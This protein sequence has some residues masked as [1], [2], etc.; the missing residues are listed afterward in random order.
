MRLTTSQGTNFRIIH[1]HTLA[2]AVNF[3]RLHLRASL[4]K[5]SMRSSIAR[6]VSRQV[7]YWNAGAMEFDIRVHS[8]EV[9]NLWW[10]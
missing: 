1:R 2:C 7:S 8:R 9:Y 10:S 4:P 5:G 6:T 3:C